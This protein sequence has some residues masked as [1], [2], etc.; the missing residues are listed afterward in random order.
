MLR[1]R[2]RG[3]SDAERRNGSTLASASQE[4]SADVG[5]GN[6]SL[7]ALVRSDVRRL[8]LFL[9]MCA[10]GPK[11]KLH[12]AARTGD[13]N[14]IKTLL[15]CDE[16]LEEI[17]QRDAQGRTPLM[18]AVA[19][20]DCDT[21]LA[22]L[23]LLL[24]SGANEDAGALPLCFA[25]RHPTVAEWLRAR[26]DYVSKLHY[27]EDFEMEALAARLGA[28]AAMLGQRGKGATSRSVLALANASTTEA[29]RLVRTAALPYGRATAW[30]WPRFARARAVELQL[31]LSRTSLAPLNDV[32]VAMCIG[33]RVAV[34]NWKFAFLALRFLIKMRAL[35]RSAR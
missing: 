25:V 9:A 34:E 10:S 11:K 35:L 21:A 3:S 27:F 12:E 23:K 17:D 28:G 15:R 24:A 22:L 8:S 29:A 20:D 31:L 18:L 7:N 33:D 2:L 14:A 16:T 19:R 30:L 13:V 1:R 6:G 4:P 32:I 5:D 26:Q